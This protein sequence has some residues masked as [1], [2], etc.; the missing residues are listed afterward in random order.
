MASGENRDLEEEIKAYNKLLAKEVDMVDLKSYVPRLLTRFYTDQIELSMVAKMVKISQLKGMVIG[1][2]KIIKY[3]ALNKGSDLSHIRRL[4]AN[5]R[6]LLG[7]DYRVTVRPSNVSAPITEFWFSA[8]AFM[9]IMTKAKNTEQYGNLCVF[10]F[11]CV[12]DYY[13]DYQS[14]RKD[15]ELANL[16]QRLD[17][18]SLN[19]RV[20]VT[21]VQVATRKVVRPA[22][23]L[24]NTESIMIMEKMD[25]LSVYVKKSQSYVDYRYYVHV[26]KRKNMKDQVAESGRQFNARI[27]YRFTRLTDARNLW[28][29]IKA[30]GEAIFHSYACHLRLINGAT[31]DTLIAHIR[32]TRLAR[33]QVEPVVSE[34]IEDV[35]ND[36]VEAAAVD[37]AAVIID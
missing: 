6:L 31:L 18:M 9:K 30:T 28:D 32:A 4:V 22:I 2:Q 13:V 35:A 23:K 20:L 16:T 21:G 17:H 5:H 34:A 12:F 19:A 8:K 15:I 25:N 26:V 37:N 7:I 33:R 10:L 14:K 36:A 24:S 29:H 27:A 3:G 11:Y 1:Q